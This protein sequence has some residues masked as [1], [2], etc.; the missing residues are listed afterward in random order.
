MEKMERYDKY[1]LYYCS[2]NMIV[3][4]ALVPFMALRCYNNNIILRSVR[5]TTSI[6]IIWCVVG[7][8]LIVGLP[9]KKRF[10]Y[11][12]IN[13]GISIVYTASRRSM[14]R[15]E[16]SARSPLSRGPDVHL[17]FVWTPLYIVASVLLPQIVEEGEGENYTA[18]CA[19]SCG[20][21]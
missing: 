16:G 19:I 6:I 12:V 2:S 4:V 15:R 7:S 20:T 10:S 13:Y 11:S 1:M 14:R 21:S 17:A 9:P 8:R 5:I 18:C 3:Q